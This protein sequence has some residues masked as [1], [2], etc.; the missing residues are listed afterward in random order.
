MHR[1]FFVS[2]AATA[3]LLI[4]AVLGVGLWVDPYGH[5]RA[6]DSDGLDR[7]PAYFLN[8]ALFKVVELKR[9]MA[10][11]A[12]R[13]E[14]V[15][16]VVGD[17][18]SNQIDPDI[19]AGAV[20]GRWLNMS[21]GKATLQENIDL[22]DQVIGRYPVGEVVWNVPFD[23]VQNY[24]IAN[25]NEMPRAWKMASEPWLHL[26]TFESLRASWYVLRKHWFD[27]DFGDPDLGL[28]DAE[29]VAY[30]LYSARV[31]LQGVP[32]PDEFVAK[33]DDVEQLAERNGVP[34]SYSRMPVHPEMVNLYRTLLAEHYNR[35][36]E[37]FAGRCMFDLDAARPGGWM[38]DQFRDSVHLKAEY[39]LELSQRFAAACDHPCAAN[40]VTAA[41][42][43]AAVASR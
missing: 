6:T 9:V 21:Y 31:E 16:L 39:R 25:K 10:D 33:R 36:Q 32:W 12:Q 15:N 4:A 26:F 5:F 30:D 18:T 17:S 11:A 13:G 41:G 7:Q 38:P 2:F 3:G 35:Y 29:R 14:K 34:I 23:R 22:L 24:L 27:V 28:R 20:G 43:S 1:L 42:T 37:L 19:V 40:K 8:R